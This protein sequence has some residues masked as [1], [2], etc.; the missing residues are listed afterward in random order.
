MGQLSSKLRS[1]FPG[2]AFWCP[3][4]EEIHTVHT[5][6]SPA[7]HWDGNA[8][9]PTILPSI[10]VRGKRR[11]TDDEYRR[12]MAGEEVDIPDRCCHSFVRAGQIEFLPDCTHA[13]AGKT[14]PLPD[15]P[16]ELRD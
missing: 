2:I 1:T 12:I 5:H 15:L 9:A 14:V 3:G 4:C 13:L 6:G 16:D 11:I 7:W 10:L 8:D